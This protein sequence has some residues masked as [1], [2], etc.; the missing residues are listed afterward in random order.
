MLIAMPLFEF[1]SE[2][3]RGEV[4]TGRVEAIDVDNAAKMIITHGLRVIQIEEAHEK[5]SEKEFFILRRVPTREIVIFVRQLATLISANVPLM[6]ALVSLVPQTSHRLLRQIITDV[7]QDIDGGTNFSAALSRYPHVFNEFF[8]SVVRSGETSGKLDEVLEYLADQF[9]REYDLMG[10]LKGVMIYPIFV[11]G[12]LIAVAILTITYVLPNLTDILQETTQTLP[13]A[14]RMLIAISNFFRNFW[15]SLLLVGGGVMLALFSYS[16]T[17]S[18]RK[19]LDTLKLKIP[20]FGP[21]FKKVYL[22]R[23]ARGLQTLIKGGVNLVMSLRTIATITNNVVFQ[24]AIIQTANSVADGNR[25]SESLKETGHFPP[26]VYQMIDVGETSGKLDIILEKV[27]MFYKR[28]VDNTVN[29]L[30]VLLEPLVIILLGIG[31][32]F[33][34]LAVIIPLYNLANQL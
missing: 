22:V 20:I 2:N 31:V 24:S 27:A 25:F 12:A 15:W 9:E 17:R 3:Q 23:F 28:E 10:R 7:A 8:I 14:T 5:L 32:T 4:V 29:A 30:M 13:L 6:R 21:L 26:L 1:R 19:V 11:L 33:I 16:R 18:G 34:L